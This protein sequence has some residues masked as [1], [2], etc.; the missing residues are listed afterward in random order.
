MSHTSLIVMVLLCLFGS[1]SCT[2]VF[3]SC[4]ELVGG[5]AVLGL[6]VVG[7]RRHKALCKIGFVIL[8]LGKPLRLIK[9]ANPVCDFV[10]G[11]GLG[12]L[13]NLCG[14]YL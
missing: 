14:S 12:D 2:F 8:F 10:S 1:G 7:A 4:S 11:Q 5:R 3:G 13:H 6:G 9:P